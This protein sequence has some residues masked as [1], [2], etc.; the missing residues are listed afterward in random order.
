MKIALKHQ[1][2]VKIFNGCLN[3]QAILAFASQEFNVPA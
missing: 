1:T 3:Y 2:T